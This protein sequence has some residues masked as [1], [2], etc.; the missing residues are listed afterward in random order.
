MGS[1]RTRKSHGNFLPRAIAWS[2]TGTHHRRSVDRDMG[3]EKHAMVSSHL[4]G[5]H[6]CPHHILSSRNTRP[7]DTSR[8]SI[9]TNQHQQRKVPRPYQILNPPKR[10][11][12]DQVYCLGPKTLLHRPPLRTPLPPLPRRPNNSLPSQHNLRIPLHPQH[13]HP[14]HLPIAPL[15]LQSPHCGFTI[16]PELVGICHCEFVWWE[17]GGSYNASRGSKGWSL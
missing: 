10:P 14:R 6:C 13:L 4:W 12:K 1:E 5:N 3:M 8:T 16:Y 9:P 7:K 11:A 2:T 15:L 17:M